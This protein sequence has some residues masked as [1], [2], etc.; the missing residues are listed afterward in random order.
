MIDLTNLQFSYQQIPYHQTQVLNIP[1]WHV[2]P[3]TRL[4][5]CGD[6]GSG[7][8][9]LL[10]LLAGL[11][12]PDC[13]QIEIAG[14][15]LTSMSSRQT[16]QFRAKHIGFISQRLN[17]I[18]YLSV[19]DNVLLAAR[20]S[21]N[22]TTRKALV[23]QASELLQQVNL[24]TELHQQKAENLSIGQQQRV[25]IVRAMIHQP[26]LILADE[27]TSALDKTNR[28]GFIQLLHNLCQQH[29]TTLV[30]VSHDLSLSTGFDQ[31]IALSDINQL[32]REKTNA[33]E[34]Q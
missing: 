23:K 15:M 9:T 22:K 10:H 17:L 16:D 5:L 18:P 30:M 19:L 6:S 29:N 21:G 8:S 27:P 13:G 1:R 20:L 33:L 34:V 32:N 2:E 28:D 11:N 26:A 14:Q 31:T 24:G 3:G 12:K 7:K 4:L 25:A